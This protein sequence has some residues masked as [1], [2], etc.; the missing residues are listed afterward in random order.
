MN[1]GVSQMEI[2]ARLRCGR[3]TFGRYLKELRGA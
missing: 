2:V 3:D 1:A